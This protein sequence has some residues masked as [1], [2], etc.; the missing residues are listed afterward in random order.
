MQR[1]HGRD[2]CQACGLCQARERCGAKRARLVLA[3]PAMIALRFAVMNRWGGVSTGGIVP[4]GFCARCDADHWS[5]SQAADHSF[6]ARPGQQRDHAGG[7]AARDH[8]ARLG[9]EGQA[10]T[11]APA[12]HA[13]DRAIGHPAGRVDAADPV[14]HVARSRRDSEWAAGQR[15]RR[16]RPA[17]RAAAVTGRT[18][19]RGDDWCDRAAGHGCL[20]VRG[21]GTACAERAAAAGWQPGRVFERMPGLRENSPVWVSEGGP[22][23]YPHIALCATAPK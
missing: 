7:V 8:H 22:T 2:H 14:D 12:Q 3:S 9:G 6:D 10:V 11:A 20:P 18:G 17:R 4:G 13:D 16:R 23:P 19:G 15:Q 5:T 21:G 1:G